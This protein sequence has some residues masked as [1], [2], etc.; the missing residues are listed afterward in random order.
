MNIKIQKT[1]GQLIFTP[2]HYEKKKKKCYLSLIALCIKDN[3]L[4]VVKKK[5]GIADSHSENKTVKTT[6][7]TFSANPLPKAVP[8]ET[9][10]DIYINS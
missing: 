6:D 8:R 10:R 3:R 7:S 5:K 1:T 9:C 4:A 2:S